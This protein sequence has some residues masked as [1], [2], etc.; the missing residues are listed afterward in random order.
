[1]VSSLQDFRPEFCTHFSTFPC[2]LHAQPISPPFIWWSVQVAKLL[3]MQFYPASRLAA[4]SHLG[5]YIL[6]TNYC[7]D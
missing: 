4:S 2:V 6:S 5:P 3:I 7:T 1:V